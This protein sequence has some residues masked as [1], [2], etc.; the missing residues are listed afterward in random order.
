[1]SKDPAVL[2]YTSDFLTGTTFLTY[3]EKGMYIT[4]LCQQHQLGSIPVGHMTN[5]CG[6]LDHPVVQKFSIDDKGCYY[7]ERMREEAIK[8]RN[9]CGTR[10]NNKKGN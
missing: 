4:L 3:E 6:S 1:M 2:F 9:Y 7:N 5:I 8:R 10:N